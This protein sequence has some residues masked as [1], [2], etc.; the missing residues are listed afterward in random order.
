M[1]VVLGISSSFIFV[2]LN[3]ILQWKSPPDRRGAVISFSNTCVFTGILL[4]SLAGGSLANAGISTTGIFLAAA[5]MT[6]AGIGW[7]FW[8]L[9]DT[10][11]RLVLVL[12][13]DSGWRTAGL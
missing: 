7:A 4:G 9:P 2:P 8:L 5:V 13:S 12:L 1:M 6:L 3:A 10:F 11:L